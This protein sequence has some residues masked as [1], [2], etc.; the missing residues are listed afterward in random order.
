MVDPRA[1]G[2]ISAWGEF[3]QALVPIG[4][5]VALFL[6][7]LWYFNRQAPTAAELL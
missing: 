7:G 5:I 3:P 6:F 2:P 4:T 1:P